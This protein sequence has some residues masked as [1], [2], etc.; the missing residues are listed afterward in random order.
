M[1]IKTIMRYHLISLGWSLLKKKKI[2]SDEKNVE[3]L[4]PYALLVRMLHGMAPMEQNMAVPQK[5]IGRIT[6]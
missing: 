3:K 4:N 2:I 6:I 5:N 1:L